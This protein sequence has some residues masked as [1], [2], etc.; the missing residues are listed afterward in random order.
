MPHASAGM[1]MI[2]ALVTLLCLRRRRGQA[3]ALGGGMAISD[4][5][6]Q[7]YCRLSAESQNWSDVP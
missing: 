6:M 1:M 7:A 5:E 4:E 2:A 3:T